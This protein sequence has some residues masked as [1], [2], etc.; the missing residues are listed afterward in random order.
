MH[1][2]SRNKVSSVTKLSSTDIELSQKIKVH[3]GGIYEVKISTDEADA[4]YTE[5]A[6]YYAPPIPPPIEMKVI[7]FLLLILSLPLIGSGDVYSV[8]TPLYFGRLLPCKNPIARGRL[9]LGGKQ[10]FD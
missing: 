6:T 3:Y 10:D 4:I 8:Y 5:P 7:F 2:V 9:M 1:E